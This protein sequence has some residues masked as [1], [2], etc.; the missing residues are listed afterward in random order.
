MRHLHPIGRWQRA[1][2][3]LLAAAIAAQLFSVAQAQPMQSNAPP[4]YRAMEAAT[5]K[6]RGLPYK[7]AVVYRQ[8][9]RDEYKAWIRKEIRSV[10]TEEQLIGV[11]RAWAMMGLLPDGTD[12]E[13]AMISMHGENAVAFYDPKQKVVFTFRSNM[14]EIPAQTW[15]TLVH[16]LTHA[17]QDQHF[18]LKSYP[19]YTMVDNEDAVRA[20]Q[21]LIEGDACVTPTIAMPANGQPHIPIGTG[22]P[23]PLKG[24]S[25]YLKNT[26]IFPYTQGAKFAKRLYDETNSFELINAAYKD[27]PKSTEQIFFPEKY[28]NK[29]NRDEPKE[30]QFPRHMNDPRWKQIETNVMGCLSLRELFAMHVPSAAASSRECTEAWMGWGGDRYA[31][32][33]FTGGGHPRHQE[34]LALLW[35]TVWDSPLDALEFD[36]LIRITYQQRYSGLNYT[37][38]DKATG[39]AVMENGSWR[40]HITR[41]GDKV[42]IIQAP[43]AQFEEFFNLVQKH[44]KN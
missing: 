12:F 41:K 24:K 13:Q 30:T 25:A 28:L 7:T 20:F 42:T 21:C 33:A 23:P 2:A 38:E 8:M 37:K 15:L 17:L 39:V 27:L 18:D 5:P 9:S 16:E 14:P 44:I 32:Y 35:M 19:E 10:M 36:D 3:A 26:L 11:S 29:A 22:A 43:P 4:Q 1:I 31:V 34:P 40:I 6:A